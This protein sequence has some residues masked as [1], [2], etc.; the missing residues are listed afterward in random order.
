MGILLQEELKALIT[1]LPPISNSAMRQCQVCGRSFTRAW[2]L[3]RHMATHMA[4]KP[5]Q[6]P[7]CPHAANVKANLVLHIRKWH[8]NVTQS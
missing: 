2:H 5:F 4:M 6:C 7:Y 1:P 3:K 8:M